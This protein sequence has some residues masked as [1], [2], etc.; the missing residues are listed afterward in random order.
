MVDA[1]D[2]GNDSMKEEAEDLNDLSD[3]EGDNAD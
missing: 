2:M 3:E 1:N